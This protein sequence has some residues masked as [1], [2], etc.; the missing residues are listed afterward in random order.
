MLH[1]RIASTKKAHHESQ[2]E[3]PLSLAVQ[4]LP[5][6]SFRAASNP[7]R[8]LRFY[9]HAAFGATPVQIAIGNLQGKLVNRYVSSGFDP[10]QEQSPT[11]KP[12]GIWL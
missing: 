10:R 7:E 5:L 2:Y 3:G 9:A 4:I 11:G 1:P 8:S 6:N 12:Q